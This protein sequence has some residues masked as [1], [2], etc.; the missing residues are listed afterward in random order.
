MS[1]ARR[2]LAARAR[3]GRVVVK[4]GS[5]VITDA[6]GRLDRRTIRRLA[7]D[8]APLA[9]PKRWPFVVSA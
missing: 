9:G 1:E 5:G 4:I 3:R 7:A 6:E 8:I 2:A